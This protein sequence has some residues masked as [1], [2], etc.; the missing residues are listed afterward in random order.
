MRRV[1]TVLGTRPEIIRLSRLIPRLDASAEHILLYT[2]QNRD[3]GLS[4]AFFRELPV[5]EP[6]IVLDPGGPGLA[7]QLAAIFTGVADAIA[8]H[9][10]ERVVILGDTNSGLAALVAARSHAHVVHLEAG[11]RCFDWRSPEEVNRRAIDHVSA[12][13]L[14]YTAGSR[15]NLLREGIEP[16]RIVV[17]G[18]PIF[19]VMRHAADAI[20]AS[21]A[22]DI[23]GVEPRRF[24]LLT[25]HRAETVDDPQ[26]LRE[27][28]Q[29]VE[30]AAARL[31]VPALF[32]IH[33]RTRDRMASQLDGFGCRRIRLLDPLGFHDFVR[34]ERDAQLVISDSGT[35]QEECAILGT[36][37][38][39]ARDYTERPEAIACG[40]S[41]LGGRTRHS[42]AAAVA[43]ALSRRETPSAPP[44]Y[45]VTDASA[46]AEQTILGPLPPS[47]SSIR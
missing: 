8:A 12:W 30:D 42:L 26:H 44:E 34:L 15:D 3:P 11:N 35:V 5:R 41:E 16:E 45:L 10:P 22:L 7:R 36:P 37:C 43:R 21:T 4:T 19:E 2:G 1:L 29:A 32:P 14:P 20:E 38:V 6:D 47:F 24:V 18:N 25:A 13:L 31:D 17:T 9:R 28:L 27:V 40:A 46:T 33:P 39:V 23:A